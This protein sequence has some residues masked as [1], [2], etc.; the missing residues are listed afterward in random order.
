MYFEN[1]DAQVL[2]LVIKNG[3]IWS[4]LESSGDR[5]ISEVSK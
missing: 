3:G 5:C 4:P 1:N 2:L